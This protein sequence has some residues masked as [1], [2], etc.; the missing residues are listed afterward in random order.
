MIGRLAAVNMVWQYAN[1]SCVPEIVRDGCLRPSN[2]KFKSGLPLVWFTADQL[3]D[4]TSAIDVFCSVRFG[5][6]AS[7]ARLV[8]SWQVLDGAGADA[9][10]FVA[11]LLLTGADRHDW[12]ATAEAVPLSD[13]V[14]EV[15]L[16]DAGD[17]AE[18]LAHDGAAWKPADAST[19]A[20]ALLEDEGP[21]RAERNSRPCRRQPAVS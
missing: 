10:E 11:T 16:N 14:F 7:D 17:W 8:R 9:T 13:L 19:T 3:W 15:L 20:R 2:E 6:R 4:R 21:V 1:W 18:S 12:F 5:M